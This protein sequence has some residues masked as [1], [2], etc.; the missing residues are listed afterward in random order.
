MVCFVGVIIETCHILP[1]PSS[2]VLFV[3]C[4]LCAVQS[5]RQ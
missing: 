1:D 4:L 2:V 3:S 5:P